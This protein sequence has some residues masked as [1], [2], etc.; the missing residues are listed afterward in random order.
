[1][2]EFKIFTLGVEQMKSSKGLMVFGLA[3]AML[4]SVAFATKN[5]VREV[6]DVYLP[7]YIDNYGQIAY[8]E[9]DS[10]F[11][12]IKVCVNTR[13]AKGHAKARGFVYNDSNRLFKLKNDPTLNAEIEYAAYDDLGLYIDI[14]RSLLKVTKKGKLVYSNKFIVEDYVPV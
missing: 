10:G 4:T 13:T 7:Y 2:M 3:I 1:M 14:K 8:D 6:F 5:K 12:T 9:F 11:A